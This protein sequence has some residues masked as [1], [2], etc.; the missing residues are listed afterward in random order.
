M[1][2]V[3]KGSKRWKYRVIAD[4]IKQQDRWLWLQQTFRTTSSLKPVCFLPSRKINIKSSKRVCHIQQFS[5]KLVQFSLHSKSNVLILKDPRRDSKPSFAARVHLFW[6]LNSSSIKGSH[7][8]LY[9]LVQAWS[10]P[11]L[12]HHTSKGSPVGGV[13]GVK[14]NEAK[15]KNETCSGFTQIS[16]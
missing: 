8:S 16:M 11:V 12:W 10:I 3:K 7:S 13:G 6:K 15:D 14:E 2:E 5:P 4:D 9:D 1:Q